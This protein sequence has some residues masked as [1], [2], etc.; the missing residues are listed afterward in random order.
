MQAITPRIY[1]TESDFQGLTNDGG[2]FKLFKENCL[3]PNNLSPCW[4]KYLQYA[5]GSPTMA[6]RRARH[7]GGSGRKGPGRCEP[8]SGC[9]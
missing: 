2:A 8:D 6:V 4:R 3:N 7:D 1:M 5:R 9:P